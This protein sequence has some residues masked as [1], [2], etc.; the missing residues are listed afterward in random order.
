MLTPAF[1]VIYP[2]MTAMIAAN[3]T[4]QLV[5]YYRNGTRLLMA[6]IIP[7]SAFAAFFAHD[8]LLAWTGDAGTAAT[9]APLVPLMIAGTAMNGIMHFPYALQLAAGRSSLPATINLVLLLLFVPM[10]VL[11]A[12]RHGIWGGA[13]A[14][15]AL[16]AAYILIG[17]WLTHR[18]IL[19]GLATRWLTRDVAAPAALAVAITGIGAL[20]AQSLTVPI[21]RLAVGAVF[22]AA[23]MLLSALSSPPAL[24]YL[25]LG[26]GRVLH[27]SRPS[28]SR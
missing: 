26:L 22:T 17:T 16:N 18:A 6:A 27:R 24:A 11:L 7:C 10:L 2:R 9:V 19:P 23:A 4:G 8:L 28:P 12:S 13:T 25:R 20:V 14:W 5:D 3:A 15:A 1:N 21:A